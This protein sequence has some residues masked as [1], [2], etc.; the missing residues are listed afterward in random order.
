M[1]RLLKVFTYSSTLYD[2][3]FIFQ[4]HFLNQDKQSLIFQLLVILDTLKD[5]YNELFPGP[6]HY[7]VNG[8]HC[9]YI[10]YNKYM[11]IIRIMYVF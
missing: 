3:L 5:G 7:I 11:Q 6:L 10:F 2:T 1:I 8:G 9:T 4:C